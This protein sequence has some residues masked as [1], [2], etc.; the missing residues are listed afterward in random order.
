MA[1]LNALRVA[2]CGLAL[3][4]CTSP[5]VEAPP[6]LHPVVTEVHVDTIS[7]IEA[8][9]T[10]PRGAEP[11][12]AYDRYYA[13]KRIND[14]N[15]VHGVFLLRHS[16]GDIDRA[17]MEAVPIPNVYR[18]APDDLPVVA[19]GGCAVVTV[20]FDTLSFLFWQLEA[21]PRDHLTAPAICNGEA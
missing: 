1:A 8:R 12:E 14:R 10:M 3:M 4:A 6:S 13:M 2:L 11:L 15:V 16:F 20:Y 5:A 7:Y 17:G 21:D 18:G 19:D 9:V